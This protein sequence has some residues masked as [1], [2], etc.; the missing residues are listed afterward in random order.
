MELELEDAYVPAEHD[1]LFER[2]DWSEFTSEEWELVPPILVLAEAGGN[3]ESVSKHLAS[4]YP[5]KIA[6]IETQGL[7]GTE[8]AVSAHETTVQKKEDIGLLA[9]TRGDV[10]VLQTSVGHPGH[11]MRGV[12][13]GLEQS[14][15]ALFHIY[16]PDPQ[17][18]GL[19]AEEVA[20]QATLAYQSRLFP[21]FKFDPNDRDSRLRLEGNPDIEKDWTEHERAVAD[22]SGSRRSLTTPLTVADWAVRDARFKEH[23]NVVGKGHRNGQVKPLAEYI[24]MDVA[25]REGIEP[26]IDVTDENDRH[27]LAIVS[28]DLV[29][30]TEKRRDAWR[31]LRTLAGIDSGLAAV[32]QSQAEPQQVTTEGTPEPT[33]QIDASLYQQLTERLL[34]LAG[35]SQDPDFF[36]QSLRKFV[37]RDEGRSTGE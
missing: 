36:K 37:T 25:E 27:F 12:G 28:P 33:P 35:Y 21:L 13:E 17:T 23:F 11:L 18:G 10:F 4:P 34:A 8:G 15:P 30:A 29:E 16:A 7:P 22:P 19:A 1:P 24:E 5:L 26:Y 14:G 6:V 9:L 31:Y 2:F 3:W 20:R 32:Q